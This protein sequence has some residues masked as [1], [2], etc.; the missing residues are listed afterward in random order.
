MTERAVSLGAL[1]RRWR[2]AVGLVAAAAIGVAYAGQVQAAPQ[3]APAFSAVE[4]ANAILFDDGPAAGYLTAL[5]RPP[6]EWNDNL[7]KTEQAV[8][9]AVASDPKWAESFA[10]QTQSGDPNQI[11]GALNDL[12][13]VSR[14]VAYDTFGKEEVDKELAAEPGAD[15]VG[16][17]YMQWM[18]IYKYM[19]FV[20]YFVITWSNVEIRTLPM[21]MDELTVRTI[22]ENLSLK[23]IG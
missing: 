6:V 10:A 22:A 19:F 17:W 4:L 1:G 7:T 13:V 3:A 23:A 21:L 14:Q 18:F 5:D 16:R 12:A 15:L 8:D 9:A 11:Q 20:R 2:W